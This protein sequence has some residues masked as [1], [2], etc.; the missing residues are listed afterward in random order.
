MLFF[1]IN[2]KSDNVGYHVIYGYFVHPNPIAVTVPILVEV[3]PA[4]C[5]LPTLFTQSQLRC[6][7]VPARSGSVPVPLR[8]R[9]GSVPAPFRLRSGSVPV[10]FRSGSGFVPVP[11]RFRSGPVPVPFRFRSGSVPFP[12][13]HAQYAGALAVAD[14]VRTKQLAVAGAAQQLAVRS[15]ADVRRVQAPVTLP[16][17]EAVAVVGLGKQR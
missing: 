2:Q 12:S 9:S 14:A 11:F 10:P 15:A 7:S 8:L 17:A 3:L 13:A 5:L 4:S 6:F 1:E 16:A